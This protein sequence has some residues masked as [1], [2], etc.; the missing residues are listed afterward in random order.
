MVNNN[1]GKK[2]ETPSTDQI[3]QMFNDCNKITLS[4]SNGSSFVMEGAALTGFILFQKIIVA[5]Y[6]KAAEGASSQSM[7]SPTPESP[8]T[9]T[10]N[11]LFKN[12]NPDH[13]KGRF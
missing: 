4:Y 3:T 1:K 7:T 5:M 10:I 9:G 2:A 12:S 6:A 11:D 8:I 13:K